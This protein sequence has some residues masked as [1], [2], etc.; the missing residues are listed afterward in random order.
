[1]HSHVSSLLDGARVE[2]RE[3]KARFTLLDTCT[4]CPLFRSD[5]EAAAVEI[6]YLKHK[7]DQSS[8]YT[9]FPLRAKRVSLSRVR[10]FMPPKR[11]PSFSR[12]SHI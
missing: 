9:V 1:V 5:L 7:L 8:R 2:L 12:R 11:T 4:T 3:L 10:F 6:K